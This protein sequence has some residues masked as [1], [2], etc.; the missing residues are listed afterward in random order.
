MAAAQGA[1]GAADGHF[2]RGEEFVRTILRETEGNPFFIEETLRHLA[3]AGSFYRREG[4]WVTDA[5][6]ISELGIP[7]GVRDV[8]GRRLS[9]LSET[10]NRVLA[11][12]AMLGREFEFEVLSRMSELGE[13]AIL[14]AVEE[15][16]SARMVVESHGRGG[17]RFAFTHAL[18]RQ[19]LVEELSLP[20][21]Q[22]LHLRAAQ[23]IEGVHQRNLEPY[24]AAL[25]NHYQMAGAAADV[26]KTIDYSLRA[27]NSAYAVFAYE[28]AGTL[29]RAALELMD[30]QGGGDKRLRARVLRLLGDLLVAGSGP[31]AIEYLEAAAPLYEELGDNEGATDAHSRLGSYLSNGEF[32]AMDMRR[33][34]DHFKKAEARLAAQPESRRLALFYISMSAACGYTKQIGDGLAAARHATE[35]CER[36]ND[37]RTRIFSEILSAAYLIASGQVA[38]GLRQA[39]KARQ[40]AEPINGAMIGSSVAWVGAL[41]I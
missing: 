4:R 27:G 39:K 10:T 2:E 20:R 26:E 17:P 33:G 21:R 28:E 15:G 38:E 29:W 13:D 6:S 7:E 25:A 37:D 11:A 41:I 12:A 24:L 30:E 32:G 14:S 9:R 34:M 23:A 16:L 36:L 40:R 35:I 1:F 18:V 3:E 8:I 5:K 31:K 19:T 22:R